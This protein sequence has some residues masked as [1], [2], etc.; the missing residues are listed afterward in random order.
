M[1]ARVDTVRPRHSCDRGGAAAVLYWGVAPAT[2]HPRG[3]Q[4]PRVAAQLDSGDGLVL[5]EDAAWHDVAVSGAFGPARAPDAAIIG[6]RL[7]GVA[8][9]G[10]VLDR[11]HV[12]DC[13]VSDS[14]W[15][16]VAADGCELT[17]VEF[18]SCRM[19]GL[20]ISR[21]RMR[22]VRFVDCRLDA[23]SLR[24]ARGSRVVFEGCDL[25]GVDAYELAL[26]E[27][28]FH[29]CNL[30]GANLSGAQ[31]TGVRLSGSTLAELRGAKALAG[32]VIDSSQVVAVG[33][34]LMAA[35]DITIDDEADAGDP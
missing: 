28:R 12:S 11:L 5:D 6:S 16:G 35:L 9:T 31:L 3:L 8:L 13:V 23:A 4:A 22:D 25:R 21:A 2:E 20:V 29:A 27:A 17:R 15:S 34:S 26:E 1:S 19:S 33:L 32:A 7:T 10:S 18:R 14:E 24:M 30:T